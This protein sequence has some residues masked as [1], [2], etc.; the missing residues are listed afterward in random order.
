VLEALDNDDPTA[1]IKSLRMRRQM[2]ERENR[3]AHVLDVIDRAVAELERHGSLAALSRSD[4]AT[5]V[6]HTLDKRALSRPQAR[7]ESVGT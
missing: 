5:L 3:D 6:S 4:Q 2:Y 7:K 1:T